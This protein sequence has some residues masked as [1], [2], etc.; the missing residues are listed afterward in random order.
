MKNRSKTL[1]CIVLVLIICITAVCIPASSYVND[2]ET[3]TADMILI[4]VDTNTVV[5][6]QKPDNKWYSG[7]LSV[8]TTY[9][10]AYED[11]ED[12]D[13]V[14]FDVE[15]SFIKKLP[16]TDGC[17]DEYVG[18]T[19]TAKDLMAIMLLTSGSDAAYALVELSSYDNAAD[20]VDA[21]NV[22]V[23]E[24]GCVDTKF[25]T[26]GY[27][28]NPTQHTTCRDLYYIYMAAR[29]TK[30]FSEIMD[31]DG[32]IPSPYKEFT[33]KSDASI[34]NPDSPY[35][36]R[37]ANDAKYSYSDK[38]YEGIALTT[39]YRDKTYF[40]AGLLGYDQRE[41]NVYADA[42]KLTT[43][44]YLNLSDRK[45]ISADNSIARV[46][47]DAGWGGYEMELHPFASAYKTL[48][49]DFDERLLSYDIKLP[50]SVNWPLFKGQGVGKAQIVY[51]SEQIED[52]KLVSETNEGVNM[53]SD[54]ARFGS[55]VWSRL[56]VNE[57]ELK[58][59]TDEKKEDQR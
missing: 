33:V 16:Y 13:A 40:F 4:N 45:V 37:Y 55:Y 56:L 51:D 36:F 20:F 19:L 6:S 39:T 23:E 25:V 24:L 8:L 7:Y 32:F 48:P 26:P 9:L 17:L 18:D 12:L 30:L 11:I 5:F 50:E 1:I 49:N 34:L 3:S 14:D 57:P 31:K 53:L 59:E 44:A 35:Y 15:E 28:D 38:T 52:V 21:M 2:V 42:K 29:E 54:S 46:N 43:W 58:P 47:V 27:S 41:E 22:K 10:V